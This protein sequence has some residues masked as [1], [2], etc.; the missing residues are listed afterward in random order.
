MKRSTYS[1]GTLIRRTLHFEAVYLDILVEGDG[2]DELLV[3]VG[4][5]E[6]A[7]R[8][9]AVLVGVLVILVQ[10]LRPAL[11]HEGGQVHHPLDAGLL[12][13]APLLP[14][15]LLDGVLQHLVVRP[16]HLV[17][18]RLVPEEHEGGHGG[19]PVACCGLL[20]LVNIHLV[21]IIFYH[22]YNS[23]KFKGDMIQAGLN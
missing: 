14:V 7:G 6:A 9:E 8:G 3:A 22:L 19:D 1:F 4:L 12:A 23:M 18:L 17:H 2:E 11:V 21:I 20:A 15:V 13:L 10:T 5:Q 16:L